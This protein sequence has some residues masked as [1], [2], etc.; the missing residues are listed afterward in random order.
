M[1]KLT[2]FTLISTLTFSVFSLSLIAS[3]SKKEAKETN[4]SEYS[5]NTVT[6]NIDLNDASDSTIRD[7]YSSLE[8]L[9]VSERQG[10][11][12]LKNLKPIL[13]DGQKY[14][15]YNDRATTA[16]WQIYEIVD[17]DWEK[18]PAS[19]ISGYNPSTNTITN[20]SYGT[21]NSNVGS[22]PYLHALYINRDV[23]TQ[24]R[25]WGNHNQDNW[26]INQEHVWPK[27]CGF[28][29]DTK[30]TGARGDLMHLWAGNG[31]VNG[32]YHNNYFYGYVDTNLSYKDAK[33]ETNDNSYS[34]L[35]GNLRGKSKT[36]GSSYTVF[37]PQDSDKGDI[38]RAIFYM[39]ARYNYLSG[40]DSDGIDAGN[41]NLEI[42]NQ[43][44]TNSAYT[45]STSTTGKMGIL[46]DLLEWNRIDPP[47]SWEIHRNNLLFNNFTNN[48]NPF[49]DYPEWAEFIWGKSEDGN[50]SSSVTGYAKPNTDTINDFDSGATPSVESISVAPTSI[51]LD[52]NGTKTQ[53]LTATVNAVGGA[54]QS[55]TWSSSKSTVATVSSSG[56]VTAKKVG[57]ATIKATSAFD[58]SKYAE[59]SVTVIDTTKVLSSISVNNPKTSYIVGDSFETPQVIAHYNDSTTQDVTSFATFEGYDLS[60]T[61]NQTVTVSYTE[62]DITKTT[63]YSIVVSEQSSTQNTTVSSTTIDI[64]N[65]N[66]WTTSAGTSVT[67]YTSFDLD[68]VVNISTTGDPNCGSFWGTSKEWRL[69]QN[70]NGNLII[71]AA[72]GYE[73]D[74]AT[75][76]FTNS[77][78][79]ILLDSSN[80]TIESGIPIDLSGSSA[81]FT[82]G[83][84]GSESKGQIRVTAI[85]VTYHS[86]SSSSITI[87]A[88]VN[89]TYY[90]GETISKSDITVKDDS[91]NI[92]TTFDF[93]NDGYQFTYKDAVSG[94]EL[95]EKT[96]T[97]AISSGSSTCSLTVQVQRKAFIE[98]TNSTITY[99]G[100]DFKDAGVTV[101]TSS[102]FEENKQV[103]IDS[104]KFSVSGYVY[105]NYSTGYHLS[106]SNSKTSA[107]GSLSNITSYPQG[108]VNVE[109]TGASP[110]IQLSKDGID[111]VDLSSANTT[112]ENYY[113]FKMFYKNT[114]QSNFVN[115]SQIEVTLKGELTSLN[116]ANWLMYED[117]TNQCV[118]KYEIAKGYFSSL[119]DSQKTTFMESDDYVIS[120]ARARFEAWA[121]YHGESII[122]DGNSYTLSFVGFNQTVTNHANTI[123][124]IVISV[125]ALLSVSS[126]AVILV[127][128]RRK[129]I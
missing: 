106:F 58:S 62:E 23:D 26:G 45:S 41:P 125:I 119:S 11:N 34:H 2:K 81:M 114:T 72:E 116:F 121:S 87:T 60:T 68:D 17:R 27:S 75:I 56:L 80:N 8:D 113:Y 107:T 52:L 25:A 54:S 40:S 78:D 7:Y 44:V 79:G 30:G 43:V 36:L 76:T 22:N 122:T 55:V 4:S 10:T 18:S 115:I 47:D 29:D 3:L 71:T 112:S 42:I 39:A 73:L 15:A 9:T 20:Y 92:I 129:H 120:K 118:N 82:V 57:T 124:I 59:C 98:P 74:S 70:K 61:G 110:D 38:A 64:V 83:S 13:K 6:K 97:N 89:K 127:I 105:N 14:F 51:E 50:Y 33:D 95:T 117:T 126:I 91:D 53:Q 111:W 104:I 101:G 19:E 100:S 16:V 1:K 85:S 12:L 63:T 69:Y 46:Q 102:S 84:S 90:V 28:N 103:T 77:N 67:C 35:A 93:A 48:R 66:N 65:K 128:K 21:S 96:F 94:G 88:S 24:T 32:D 31:K 37:E 49:I 99:T 5:T 108:I 123:T 86:S 109:P